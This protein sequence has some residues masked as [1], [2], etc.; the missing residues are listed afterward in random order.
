MNIYDTLH[1]ALTIYDI[2]EKESL[3]NEVIEYCSTAETVEDDV[4]EPKV[5][6]TPSYAPLCHILPPK[7]LPKRK[8]IAT[9]E[10]LGMLLHSIAHIEYSAIDLALDAV[11]RYRDMPMDF[12]RDWLEVASD[13]IRH[14][15]MLRNI[16]KDTGYDYGDF[17]VHSGL[18][19]IS[20]ETEGDIL[21][22]MAIVP[23]HYEATGLD[24]NPKISAKLRKAPSNPKIERTIDALDIIYEEEITH[25]SKG[26]RWFKYIC[27]QRGVDERD[28][29]FDILKK[30]DLLKKRDIN[31]EAR[32]KAGFACEEL[33]MMGAKSC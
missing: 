11:Y 1:K 28:T 17:P 22:R 3:T 9:D 12:K 7:E 16:L 2:D 32:L 4:K 27:R 31:T 24:V 8:D 10:G 23:R 19:D 14:F 30:Y 26:D 20:M 21:E 15:K 6:T 18:F 5:F 29:F 13:E 25:V 33:K